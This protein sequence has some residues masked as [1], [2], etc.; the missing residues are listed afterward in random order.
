MKY[1]VGIDPGTSGVKCLII[2][3]AGKVIKSAT[4]EY[5]LY[6]PKPAWSEQDPS[7][8][9]EGTKEALKEMLTGVDKTKIAA[10]GFSGQMHGL[11]ALDGSNQVIR[12]AFLWNDPVSYTHL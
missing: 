10:I 3:E 1:L 5:P 9:W 12:R 11:V 8:W 2:D 7:D 6:T 4:R